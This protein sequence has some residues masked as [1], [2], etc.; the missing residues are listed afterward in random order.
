MCNV[1]RPSYFGFAACEASVAVV[2]VM[3]EVL[4]KI[5]PTLWELPRF[6]FQTNTP[7][8]FP[9][10][11]REVGGNSLTARRGVLRERREKKVGSKRFRLF[12]G[13]IKRTCICP[14]SGRYCD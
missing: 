12:Y 8:C 2:G 3:H 1:V 13:V 5:R 6:F 7:H 4:I 9:F 11:W 10:R 14:V